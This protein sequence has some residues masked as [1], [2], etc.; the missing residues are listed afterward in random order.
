MKSTI[1]TASERTARRKKRATLAV[2]EVLANERQADILM[3]DPSHG[4]EATIIDLGLS[5]MECDI[6]RTGSGKYWTSFD[7]EIFNGSGD[8]QYDI[9]RM[10]RHHNSDN[11]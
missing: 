10:M 8:Y 1:T 7:E 5:R 4:V 9:Y 6:S 3:D 2:Q 11:W